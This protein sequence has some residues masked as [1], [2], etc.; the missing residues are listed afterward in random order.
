M[1][2]EHLY[3]EDGSLNDE[4]AGSGVGGGVV[5]VLG[6]TGFVGRHVVEELLKRGYGVRALVRDAS[7]AAGVLPGY[8]TDERLT[9]VVGDVS[10]DGAMD[11]LRSLQLDGVIN[12]IGIRRETSEASFEVAHV[13]ATERSLDLAMRA[14]ARRYVL[15]S[16]LGVG[17]GG[18]NDYVRSKFEAETLVRRS[19][20]GGGSGWTIF[21]PSVVHGVD[22]EMAQM[23]KGWAVGRMA[24]WVFMPWFCRVD[25]EPGFP[26]KPPKLASAVIAPVHVDDV[27]KAIVDSLGC[28]EAAGEVYALAGPDELTWPEFLR[29]AR[30]RIPMAE[31]TRPI[32]PL[33]GLLG[34]AMA[35]AAKPLGLSA[36]LPFGP[37]EPLLAIRDNVADTTK[38]REDLGFDPKPFRE[39]F[40]GYADRI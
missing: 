5:A 34:N 30:E 3:A 21:R 31:V 18:D 24:P 27:S 33:P 36:A 20:V 23:L 26:P 37:S 29:F 9:V 16:A 35:I 12:C 17:P 8:G 13:R 11:E 28:K 19:G 25:V 2:C 4:S 38:A 32:L 7:K 15:V 39:T 1:F 22:G 6:A 14:E 10:D 40:A